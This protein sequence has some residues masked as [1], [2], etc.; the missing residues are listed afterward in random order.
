MV[1]LVVP[2]VVAAFLTD[3]NAHVAQ[4][5]S[6]LDLVVH[7]VDRQHHD[8]VAAAGKRPRVRAGIHAEQRDIRDTLGLF[9]LRLRL[10]RD[11]EL[12]LILCDRRRFQSAEHKGGGVN[13]NAADQNEQ[14]EQ[15]AEKDFQ[16]RS[17]F[18][19]LISAHGA[20]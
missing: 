12:R 15:E 18:L 7:I 11:A 20:L 1:Q 17:F 5:R 13:E 19:L 14:R 10:L 8:R 16:S 4:N 9:R 3:V 2:R 6:Q